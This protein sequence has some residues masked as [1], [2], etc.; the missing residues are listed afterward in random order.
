VDQDRFRELTWTFLLWDLAGPE[1]SE[2]EAEL[3]RRGAAGQSEVRRMREALASLALATPATPP[4]GA[5][6]ERVLARI[7]EAAGGTAAG[8]PAEPEQVPGRPAAG[9]RVITLPRRPG[10]WVAAAAVAACAAGLL[11]VWNVSLRDDLA[12]LRSELEQARGDL[13]VAE[14]RLASADSARTELE[15]YRRDLEALAS[16]V[17]SVHTLVGTADE[18]EARARVFLDPETGR[19]ILFVYDLPVLPPQSVYELWAIKGGTPI[20][21]GTFATKGEPRARVE[22]ADVLAVTV[23]PAPGGPAPTGKMVLSSSS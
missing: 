21:A 10:E 20:P 15:A 7:E 17:G 19:A 2:W 16:P 13:V 5:L 3:E 14:G 1:Q 4:P 8:W 12:R 6:R 18:P 11:A 9:P 23:E 22:G